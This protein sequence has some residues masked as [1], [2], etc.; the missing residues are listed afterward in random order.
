MSWTA[1][2]FDPR[3]N[4]DAVTRGFGSKDD[5]LLAACDLM[6]RKCIVRFVHGPDRKKSMPSL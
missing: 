6:R 1:H 5:A 2:Y 3:L 4:R